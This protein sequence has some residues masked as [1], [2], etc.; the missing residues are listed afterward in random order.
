MNWSK[1]VI[2]TDGTID[3]ENFAVKIILRLRPTTKI[4]NMNKTFPQTFDDEFH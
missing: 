1:S 4:F 3:Q 2:P